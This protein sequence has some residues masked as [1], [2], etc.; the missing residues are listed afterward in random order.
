MIAN[1]FSNRVCSEKI[2]LLI[3]C[4]IKDEYCYNDERSVA[5]VAAHSCFFAHPIIIFQ[6]IIIGYFIKLYSVIFLAYL[7][8]PY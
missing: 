3:Y 6:K 8:N 2:K 1:C 4:I 5:N 7:D